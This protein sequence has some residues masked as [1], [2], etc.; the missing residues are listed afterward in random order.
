M[1]TEWGSLLCYATATVDEQNYGRRRRFFQL[2]GM[3]LLKNQTFV[4]ILL[5]LP[6][7]IALC[8]LHHFPNNTKPDKSSFP[9][10]QREEYKKRTESL[11][12]Y[13]GCE[14]WIWTTLWVLICKLISMTEEVCILLYIKIVKC[15]SW[16]SLKRP[17]RVIPIIWKIKYFC[18][19]VYFNDKR[20]LNGSKT[21]PELNKYLIN[22]HQ[23]LG[24][25]G[26]ISLCC[27]VNLEE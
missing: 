27:I 8:W 6:H 24:W 5:G 11:N 18:F 15:W 2:F 3:G 20:Y 12:Q 9:H 4:W 21:T 25:Y 19:H 13:A 26:R 7:C 23:S 17:R 16:I 14:E 10:W 22:L 1:R